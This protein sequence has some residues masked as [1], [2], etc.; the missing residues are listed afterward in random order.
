MHLK[1]YQVRTDCRAYFEVLN[2]LHLQFRKVEGL[3]TERS[4]NDAFVE[5]INALKCACDSSTEVLVVLHGMGAMDLKEA[6]GLNPIKN[7]KTRAP[8]FGILPNNCTVDEDELLSKFKGLTIDALK[9][10]LKHYKCLYKA[11]KTYGLNVGEVFPKPA[12]LTKRF[13]RED[14]VQICPTLGFQLSE[15]Q[16]EISQIK[17]LN[18]L[19]LEV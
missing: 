15:V 9:Q 16:K 6:I 17:T 12:V 5:S 8:N 3:E 2:M 18:S 14:C 19:A 4:M 7:F 1:T 10:F 13:L 11:V